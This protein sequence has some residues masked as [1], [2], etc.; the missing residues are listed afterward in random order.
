M[1]PIFWP[2]RRPLATQR[3]TVRGV[4]FSRCAALAVGTG[5]RDVPMGTILEEPV[6]VNHLRHARHHRKLLTKRAAPWARLAPDTTWLRDYVEICA[7]CT[8]GTFGASTEAGEHGAGAVQGRGI[9]SDQPPWDPFGRQQDQRQYQGQP[10]DR[11][12]SYGQQPYP[13]GQPPYGQQQNAHLQ[14]TQGFYGQQP[15][16]LPGP[17]SGPRA[18]RSWPQRHKV[19]TVVGGTLAAF[20]LIGAIGAATSHG[21]RHPASTAAVSTTV[22]ATTAAATQQPTATQQATTKASARPKASR[23]A[24]AARTADPATACG[25][26]PNAS[27]DIYVW[28]KTPGVQPLAQQLGGEWVWNSATHTCQTSVQLM[29]SSAP[30][31]PGNCTQVGYVADNPGYDPNATPAKPLKVVAGEIGP[32]C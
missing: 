12:P 30:R 11:P 17:G 24:K 4:T 7:L 5:S 19:L 14:Q 16:P 6:A 8:F 27:G 1:Q 2:V 28:I 21:S 23:K 26:R 13:Q 9:V 15:Q 25:S 29:I 18:R 32:A 31:T 20:I 10:Q 3:R 22:P